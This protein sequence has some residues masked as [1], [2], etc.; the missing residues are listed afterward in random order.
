MDW[1]KLSTND[2]AGLISLFVKN[3]ITDLNQ[4][5][6]LY[7]NGGDKTTL[8]NPRYNR[9]AEDRIYAYL[10]DEGL[11][12]S[13]ASAFM[14]NIAVES[15]LNADINQ[16]KDGPAKGLL[17]TEPD[18]YKKLQKYNEVPYK[19]GTGL[20]PD[21]QHQLDY[22]INKGVKNYT[23]GEWGRENYKGKKYK[24]ARDARIDFND[25]NKSAQELSDIL[26]KSYFRPG[27]PQEWRRDKMTD[28]FYNDMPTRFPYRMD[29][30]GQHYYNKE[31]KRYDIGGPINNQEVLLLDE[32]GGVSIQGSTVSTTLS[33]DQWNNLYR[34]NKVK[35]TDIPR[36]Y[37]PWIEAEN[38]Q[39]KRDITNTIN[40]A[41][42][43]VTGVLGGSMGLAGLMSLAPTIGT[44]VSNLYSLYNNSALSKI[45]DLGLTIDGI[46]NAASENGIQKTVNLIK[47]KDYT[48]AALSGLGDA[49]DIAGGVGYIK[50]LKLIPGL[51]NDIKYLKNFLVDKPNASKSEIAYNFARPLL[52]AVGKPFRDITN[53]LLYK[54]ML[55]NDGDATG[56]GII[57]NL[58]GKNTD[59]PYVLPISE[60]KN[61]FKKVKQIIDNYDKT[62]YDAVHR[63]NLNDVYGTYLYQNL[64]W[65]NP[66][67]LKLSTDPIG[68]EVFKNTKGLSRY[69]D[70]PIY[71]LD[72]N[73]VPTTL[74]TGSKEKVLKP[75][76]YNYKTGKANVRGTYYKNGTN[77]RFIES[78]TT[79][80]FTYVNQD[81]GGHAIAVKPRPDLQ[82]TTFGHKSPAF[83]VA[84]KDTQ[85][86]TP[87]D[88]VTK[89]KQGYKKAIPLALL[90]TLGDDF[91]L[92]G[93]GVYS[94]KPSWMGNGTYINFEKDLKTLDSSFKY[95]K[96][97]GGPL[98]SDTA[99]TFLTDW[100]SS[101]TTQSMI[102]Q[103]EEQSGLPQSDVNKEVQTA[104][105]T[106]QYEIHPNSTN[107]SVPLDVLKG[108]A[109]LDRSYYHT[110]EDAIKQFRQ[111]SKEER[112][113]LQRINFSNAFNNIP[114]FGAIYTKMNGNPF[115]LY[116]EGMFNPSNSIH[117]I[118]HNIQQLMPAALNTTIPIEHKLNEGV[119]SDYYLDSPNEI[120]SR[121]MQLRQINNLSPEKRD[122]NSKDAK[123]FIGRVKD[124]QLKKELER[125]DY[126]TVANYLNYMAD[127]S[128]YTFNPYL[129]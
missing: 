46:R 125:M 80:R 120:R 117:E 39:Y 63:Q 64:L 121:I 68:Q 21:E 88:Y 17:Q 2:K 26:M 128:A 30:W 75:I 97:T 33:R 126:Q 102:H 7:A 71:E 93:R 110:P 29:E 101:P 61:P 81:I 35:L 95:K 85:H 77:F 56:R 123:K 112:E 96:A 19:F 127:N 104:L 38:S 60:I 57:N 65:K 20:T 41:G 76:V 98:K 32:D 34:Q 78:P 3:G 44:S 25:P 50:D 105:E 24:S 87:T 82:L 51:K 108:A 18:R 59:V 83:D 99:D 69:S 4:M 58:I 52:R 13:Q 107:D 74:G 122:Y 12:H 8:N 55:L 86:F 73:A 40:K 53:P 116:K 45:V 67:T 31:L 100:Y 48:K 43:I 114:N 16:E 90:D 70:L 5:R 66:S 84:V 129:T 23:S 15:L 106:P 54:A 10:R 115:I 119:K 62:I 124:K 14:G 9:D 92:F 111:A 27:K 28:Y 72:L 37:Q 94:I 118:D 89:W 42:P 79:S 109:G 47:D 103:I 22:F 1:K 91:N 36:K 49:L 6:K 11:S 113:A